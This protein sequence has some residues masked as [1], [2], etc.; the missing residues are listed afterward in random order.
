MI[1]KTEKI[2]YCTQKIKDIL[3]YLRQ[4]NDWE[5]KYGKPEN[6]PLT[7]WDKEIL[8]LIC[9]EDYFFIYV[10][11]VPLYAVNVTADS[12]LTAINELVNKLAVKF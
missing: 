11:N 9:G 4:G 10:G 3:D 8:Q 7:S 5:I 12:V 1:D 6:I 2:L